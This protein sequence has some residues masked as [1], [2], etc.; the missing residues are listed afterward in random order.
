[1]VEGTI[2][3]ACGEEFLYDAP[4]HLLADAREYEISVRFG[5][6]VPLLCEDCDFDNEEGGLT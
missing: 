6:D 1:M 3:A 2:C 4:Q 5:L